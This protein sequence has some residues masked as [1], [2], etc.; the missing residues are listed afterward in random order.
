MW[1]RGARRPWSTPRLAPSWTR[2]RIVPASGRSASSRDTTPDT[3]DSPSR[4]EAAPSIGDTLSARSDDMDRLKASDVP[5]ELL[6]DLDLYVHGNMDRR[7][8]I[9]RC[10]NYVVGG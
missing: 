6:D 3:V 9:E 10:R 7:T 2:A 8:F 5:R 4:S 1:R